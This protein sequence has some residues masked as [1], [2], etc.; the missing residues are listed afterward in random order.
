MGGTG[1]E[2]WRHANRD[3]RRVCWVGMKA[4]DPED[5]TETPVVLES[6]WRC[7]S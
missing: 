5:G 3:G 1:R 6:S 7:C 2:V 4:G